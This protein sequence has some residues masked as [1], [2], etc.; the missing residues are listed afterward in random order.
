MV[1]VDQEAEE[2]AASGGARGGVLVQRADRAEQ[3]VVEVEAVGLA[4]RGLV[5]G[6]Q[7]RVPGGVL[8][9]VP[10]CR[11]GGDP[12]PV[13]DGAELAEQGLRLVDAGV[14]GGVP[15]VLAHNSGRLGAFDDAEV[16]RDADGGAVLAQ[17]VA[18]QAV[19]R[20]D[21]HRARFVRRQHGAQ[22]PGHLV[23]GLAGEGDGRHA[24]R[25]GAAGAHQVR[26]AGADDAG[27]PRPGAGDHQD[28][29][30]R[31]GDRLA[32]AV[33][34]GGEQALVSVFGSGAGRRDGHGVQE[35]YPGRWRVLAA[36]AGGRR[37]A[38][39]EVV[40]LL[41]VRRPR[42]RWMESE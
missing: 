16:G 25:L 39:A 3:E 23:G 35:S 7:L 19:E 11:V 14:D 12:H 37:A 1:L 13:L 32:L 26:D 9:A 31:G 33:V 5:G 38:G 41:C 6:G 4:E 8:V 2:A 34:E 21:P 27:L 28:R 17:Q 22:A 24:V 40:Y 10:A 15:Y 36:L 20:G 29:A 42:S 30:V 18:A